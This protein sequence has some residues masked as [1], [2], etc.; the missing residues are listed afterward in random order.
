MLVNEKDIIEE[1]R[2]YRQVLECVLWS[3]PRIV[4]GK[5]VEEEK[6]GLGSIVRGGKPLGFRRLLHNG[7][8]AERYGLVTV[9]EFG[10]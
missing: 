6:D 1:E 7:G 9:V 10:L 5:L 2:Q 3:V 4:E 8:A